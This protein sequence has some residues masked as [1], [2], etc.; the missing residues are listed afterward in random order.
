ML[1]S[2]AVIEISNMSKV[3]GLGEASTV[4]LDSVDLTIKKGE[5][6]AIMGPSGSGKSTLM[7]LI[8]L[9]D[10][11]SHGEYKLSGKSVAGLRSRARARIRRE[12]IGFIF[13]SFNLLGRMR[14]IDNVALPLMYSKIGMTERLE[15]ASKILEKLGMKEREYY[16]P[17][18]LSGGQLQRVSIARAL[19]NS[20][21]IILADEP[22]G[23]LDSKNGQNIMEI[24][25]DLHREGNTLIM[26]THDATMAEYADRILH[27]LD[28]KID[29]D[30]S[31]QP[32][33]AAPLESAA[34]AADS[35]FD[36]VVDET[37]GETNPKRKKSK[38]NKQS[39][40]SKK[41]GKKK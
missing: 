41:K 3:Y 21:S 20:P 6:V 2:M 31:S 9:L 36:G 1:L 5:F 28:G 19:A 34:Q 37:E 25:K 24:L 22:T 10:T 40:K 8:G 12:K 18:Q 38:P 16:M 14:V 7:N 35:D 23:N 30:I 17:N 27:M 26:V 29:R 15:K 11:P 32:Q 13:Q 33:P 39:K 4:A